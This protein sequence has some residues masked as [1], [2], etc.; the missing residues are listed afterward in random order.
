MLSNFKNNYLKS[1][2]PIYGYLT[3]LFVFVALF[4]CVSVG[5]SVAEDTPSGREVEIFFELIDDDSY[6]QAWWEGSDLLHQLEP[7]DHWVSEQRVIRE[8]FGELQERTVKGV[9]SRSYMPGLPDGEYA[10]LTFDVRYE[11]KAKGLEILIFQK[12]AYGAWRIVS[13]RLR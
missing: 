8:L 5:Y 2:R 1:C 10:I 13:Y 9:A 11:N 3:F 7:L 6:Q 12:D 4:V